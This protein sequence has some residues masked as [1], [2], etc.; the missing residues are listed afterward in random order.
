MGQGSSGIGLVRSASSTTQFSP[1]STSASSSSVNPEL[2]TAAERVVSQICRDELAL[3]HTAGYLKEFTIFQ[4]VEESYIEDVMRLASQDVRAKRAIGS[5]VGMAVA[6]SVGG[7]FEFIP[8]GTG[9]SKFDAKTLKASGVYNKFALK[10]GQWTDDTS[11]GLCMADSL[12]V[13]NGY[14]GR[15]IRIRFWNW[16]ERGY[17]NTFRLDA[18]RH[19]SVGLGGN[20]SLS[21]LIMTRKTTLGPRYEGLGEDAGNGS[22]MR[23][24]PVPIYFHADVDLAI[25]VSAE[26]SYTTHPGP[27]A[28]DACAFLGFLIVRAITRDKRCRKSAKRFLDDASAEYLRRPEV[29]DQPSLLKLLK[30]DEPSGSKERC[31]NWRD[32]KGPYLLETIANRGKFYNGYPVQADYFGSYSMDG[33]A[34]ALHSMYHTKSFMA[35]VARCVNYLGDADSTGAICGQLA[36]AFYGVDAIDD[37]LVHRLRQWDGGQIALRGALLYVLGVDLPQDVRDKAAADCCG[38][39]ACDRGNPRQ[40]PR[41]PPLE[42]APAP[43][44]PIPVYRS[45][46][47]SPGLQLPR[48]STKRAPEPP[49]CKK[50]N[51]LMCASLPP[52][53]EAVVRA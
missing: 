39:L 38:S 32:P 23:L 20:V 15:D 5:L 44:P 43:P 46:P 41:S 21:L 4:T 53:R 48:E 35:A 2:R 34:I 14:D 1:R 51:L 13:R 3:S 9:G 33:L 37:R 30:S 8:V 50:P 6:D 7:L 47:K 28:A 11:M 36:G 22:V 12:L 52:K 25:R 27:S 40:P 29:Q 42:P 49:S 26:S 24:A 10:P 45:P 19:E 17:N 16:W 31:W 18:E